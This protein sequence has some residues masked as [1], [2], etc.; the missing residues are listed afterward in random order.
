MAIIITS[1]LIGSEDPKI[2]RT[3]KVKNNATFHDL[4]RA[5]QRFYNFD[6]YHLYEFL[7]GKD[8]DV[9]LDCESEEVD[10]LLEVVLRVGE[11]FLYIYDFGDNWEIALKITEINEKRMRNPNALIEAQGA[12][13]IEDIGGIDGF[14]EFKENIKHAKSI[15]DPEKL[16][17]F[18]DE[19]LINEEDLDFDPNKVIYY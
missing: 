14:N 12:G 2:T 16:K 6:D 11:K 18:M 4:H 9:M 19:N 1:F 3:F 5:L 17:K 8:Q 13:P 7:L 15:K 10:A